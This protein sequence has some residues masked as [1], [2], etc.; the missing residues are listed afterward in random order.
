MTLVKSLVLCV[1]EILMGAIE[2]EFCFTFHGQTF[3]WFT[4]PAKVCPLSLGGMQNEVLWVQSQPTDP[5]SYLHI[6]FSL[7]LS[8]ILAV[9]VPLKILLLNQPIGV[10]LFWLNSKM[11]SLFQSWRLNAKYSASRRNPVKNESAKLFSPFFFLFL[12]LLYL[13]RGENSLMQIHW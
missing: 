6:G 1:C 7:F 8:R 10:R 4:S 2:L 13:F 11:S 9:G 5:C 12:F 3:C